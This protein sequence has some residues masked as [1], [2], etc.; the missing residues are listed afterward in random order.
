MYKNI[1]LS[2]SFG[3]LGGLIAFWMAYSS[4]SN[5]QEIKV[6]A[7]SNFSKATSFNNPINSN[8]QD[9]TVA[10]ERSV[11]AVV[12]IK[13]T[14][15]N[16]LGTMYWNPYDF[17][18]GPSYQNQMQISAGSGV[19]ISEDGYVVTN[20][21]VIQDAIKIEV[22]LNNKKVYEATVIGSDLSADLALL[23][24][25]DHDFPFIKMANSDDAKVGEWVL[26]V[27]NPFNLT[28]TV[29]AGIVSA[30]ARD[31]DVLKNDYNSGTAALE[32]FIQ[33]DAAVNP[34]NSG[35]ALVNLKGELI[36]INTAIKSNTGSYAGY[37]FAIP[38]NIVRKVVE[39][40]MEYGYVQ[41]VFLGAEWNDIDEVIA[42]QID[43]KNYDGVY[44]N[45]V[46]DGGSAASS[47]ILA[48]DVITQIEGSKIRKTTELQEIL[49]RYRPGDKI[50][51]MV[52]RNKQFL[53][54]DVILK[55]KFGSTSA[56]DKNKLKYSQGLGAY[57]EGITPE[58]CEKYKISSGIRVAKLK[59]G[60]LRRQGLNEGYIITKI[61]NKE[62]IDLD[63]FLS[64]C[65]RSNY[66]TFEGFYPNGVAMPYS[67]GR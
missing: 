34:G 64:K 23:K 56:L 15:K 12:H 19:I 52:L 17:L 26:A 24:I 46:Y 5:T 16:Q 29:T 65:E 28:S 48:G 4:I 66:V 39:D 45:K 49:A 20:N 6:S 47:G 62:V 3:L 60:M 33:T 13:C 18:F 41:R 10:A 40:F 22:A 32:T 53:T 30:K 43:V 37:A 25:E 31:I 42:K 14:V 44:I 21:H 54:L 35:G 58:E 1:I 55:N 36:G 27:G 61:N 8:L 57:F 11:D 51:L 2:L 59:N 7:G 63:D 38:S 67:F 9:F 50:T